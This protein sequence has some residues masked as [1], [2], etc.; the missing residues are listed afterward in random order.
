MV[1]A[2]PPLLFGEPAAPPPTTKMSA[3][4]ALSRTKEPDCLN[5]RATMVHSLVLQRWQSRSH[6]A[7]QGRSCSSVPLMQRREQGV[8]DV[9]PLTLAKLVPAAQ[10]AH[11]VLPAVAEKVPMGQGMHDAA[12]P[13]APLKVPAGHTLHCVDPGTSEKLPAPQ[14]RHWLAPTLPEKLPAGQG[15]QVAAPSPEKVPGPQAGQ[16][17]AARPAPA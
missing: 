10:A 6:A 9:D 13:A 11:A 1:P 12:D 4:M 14:G 15:V 16:A 2:S 5:W 17:A 8:H 7:S 3:C